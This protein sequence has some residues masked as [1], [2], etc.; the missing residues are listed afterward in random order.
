MIIIHKKAIH[1]NGLILYGGE[2]GIRTLAPITRPNGFRDRPLQPD[3]G[4]SPWNFIIQFI[5][6]F[7]KI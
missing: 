2:R 4:T 7:I 5:I 3:L 6:L 1:M